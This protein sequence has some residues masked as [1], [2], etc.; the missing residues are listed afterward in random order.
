MSLRR[1]TELAFKALL[2]AGLP[3]PYDPVIAGIDA[4]S[5]FTGYENQ[6]TV[7]G[8][9]RVIINAIAGPVVSPKARNVRM[10][11]EVLVET[12]ADLQVTDG[13]T[14][15][16]S[17]ATFV[18]QVHQIIETSTLVTRLQAL[19]GTADIGN[20]TCFG[21][22]PLGELEVPPKPKDRVFRDGWGYRATV[23]ECIAT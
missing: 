13:T 8:K 15:E 1:K 18:Q 23:A 10:R 19:G 6:R 9:Q 5:V 7:P 4:G 21:I 11:V 3:A 16:V 20:F 17:H 12:A 2:V 22:V 14:P